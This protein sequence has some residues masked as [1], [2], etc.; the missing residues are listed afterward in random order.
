[1][2][3]LKYHISNYNRD[4]RET[5]K[6]M[7]EKN[8]SAEYIKMICELY[9]D[10]YDDREEDSKPGGEDWL[11]GVPADH[12]SLSAFQKKLEEMGMKL[13]RTKVQKILITGGCWTTERSR[14]VQEMYEKLRKRGV[15]PKTAVKCIADEL[16]IST[17]SVNINL[18]YEKTVY[19]LE[20]KSGNAKRI[21]RH[22]AKKRRSRS[23]SPMVFSKV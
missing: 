19:D 7:T 22:R 18:P 1:M 13:S 14:E 6:T 17:V 2:A 10:Y 9:G 16:E 23:L 21:E 12:T 8:P 3:E 5:D 15:A 20:E 11:P 4:G